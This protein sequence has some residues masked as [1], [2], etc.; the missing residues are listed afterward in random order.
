MIPLTDEWVYLKQDPVKWWR[1]RYA[2]LGLVERLV[3]TVFGV[4][5]IH[6]AWAAWMADR[7]PGHEALRPFGELDSGTRREDDPSVR[8]VR[9]VAARL[10]DAASRRHTGFS[11][12]AGLPGLLYKSMC[13]ACI[14]APF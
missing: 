5:D 8:A 11:S 14:R 7:D 2:E 6:D 9:T 3:P 12:T 1:P 13:S 10:A 4:E